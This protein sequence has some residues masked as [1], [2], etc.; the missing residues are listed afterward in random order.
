MKTTVYIGTS[1]D[2]FIARKDG[3]IDW[4]M[5][6][7]D[8]SVFSSY[9]ELMERVDTVLM[10]RHTF[11]KV[12]SFS[13]WPYQ[14]EIHV[15]S[16]TLEAV[17]ATLT[18]KVN[19]LSAGPAE[20]LDHLSGKGFTAVYIDGGRLIQSFLQADLVDELIIST[21]P[22][23]LGDGISLFGLL[24]ADLAFRHIKTKSFATGLVMSFYER[25]RA[26]NS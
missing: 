14:K 13:T 6:Y 22:L 5:Q 10:G 23:L 25:Q 11:E 12:C 1:L 20:A 26:P 9:E 17:P 15:L 18:G 21:V 2:G 7:G 3:D 4:L 24:Q 8:E 16:K 19:L